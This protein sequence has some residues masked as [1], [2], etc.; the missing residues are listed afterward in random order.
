[1]PRR[2][3]TLD[4]LA[5]SLEP[6][7]T[8]PLNRRIYNAVVAAV[9]NGTLQA[10]DRLPSSRVLART[11][12]VGRNTVT[13]AFEQLLAEGFLETRH[14]SGTF[15][16]TNLPHELPEAVRPPSRPAPA[17]APP[18]IARRAERF[19]AVP[20]SLKR[21]QRIAPFRMNM[22]ALD[23]FP[24]AIWADL[25]HAL[26]AGHRSGDGGADL[27]GETDAAGYRPLREAIARHVRAAR[28]VV[29]EPEQ[30]IV[31]AGAQQGIDLAVRLLLDPGDAAW[32]EDPGFPGAIAA[33]RAGGA[34]LVPVPV[35]QDGLDVEVGE[36]LCAEARVAVVCPSSQFPLGV[37]LSL[38]RRLALLDWAHSR[39]AWIIE[40]DYDSEFRYDGRPIASLQGLDRGQRVVYV[41]TFSKVLFPSLRLAYVIVPS[42]LVELFVNAR[43]V[44]GRYSPVLEQ[45]LVA[46]FMEEGHLVRHIR[47]MRTLYTKRRA[48][49]ARAMET[50]AGRFIRL[51]T[52]E[53]GL[54]AVGWLPA[55]W[56]DE[57]VSA[58]SADQGL[59]LMPLSRL[60]LN[61]SLPPGLILGFGA[62]DEPSIEEGAKRLAR[63]LDV[64]ER[65]R[66]RART[67]R[68][69]T[70][71]DARPRPAYAG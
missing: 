46:R 23:A 3:A 59:E 30:V 70:R 50:H 17:A 11:I 36:R 4:F 54:Q 10:G 25:S 14:G 44:S 28:G 6:A 51:Q 19:A 16:S 53:T 21:P 69:A 68:S 64:M 13:L 63:V 62:F 34:R 39:N 52:A 31:V 41:G 22:P 56:S 7:G 60:V 15:V 8:T 12:A 2:A 55:G 71:T 37:T 48:A 24:A 18:P 33:L 42:S 43:I 58:R 9:L 29:C 67:S 32:C 45:A 1:M 20:P 65:E 27:L 66:A 49:L 35:D 38:R 26:F 61:R 5:F 57:E 40:D 47:R